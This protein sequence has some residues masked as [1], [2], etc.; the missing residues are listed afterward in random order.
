MRKQTQDTKKVNTVEV[1]TPSN[2]DHG[3]ALP[4]LMP[5]SP[6]ALPVEIFT[7]ALDRRE[8]NR[9]A[10]LKWIESNLQHGVDYGQILSLVK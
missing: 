1:M 10:L 8:F 4:S 6:L 3:A 7:K 9:K 5:K 2:T